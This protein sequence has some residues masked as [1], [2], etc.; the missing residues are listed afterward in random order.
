[1][2][3]PTDLTALAST[4]PNAEV[5]AMR[6]QLN[7]VIDSLRLLTAKLD[8]DAG[9]TDT[10]YRSLITDTGVTTAP[11]KLTRIAG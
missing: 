3:N 7:N 5:D 4:I 10:T 8:V 11:A 6:Q 1:M 9:V 2:A